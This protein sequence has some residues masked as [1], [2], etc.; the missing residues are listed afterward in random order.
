M[1]HVHVYATETDKKALDVG[2]REFISANSK[3]TDLIV[4]PE[5]TAICE[6]H[7]HKNNPK[8]TEACGQDNFVG[9]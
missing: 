3:S 8:A 5:R 7:F 1:L 6:N 9:N 4:V 2:G